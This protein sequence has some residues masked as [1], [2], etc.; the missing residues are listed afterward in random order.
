MKKCI[1]FSFLLLA[2]TAKIN[3]SQ[4]AEES[5]SKGEGLAEGSAQTEVTTGSHEI[6]TF[7]GGCFWCMGSPFEKLEGV[8]E[9]I[10]G[11]TGGHKDN[12]T[13]KEVSSGTTG[14]LEAIQIKYDPSQISYPDL[15]EVFWRQVDPTDPGGQFVDRGQQYTTAIF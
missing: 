12:P 7:A 10:S 1:I 5:V 4:P 9:V 13:Y 6:A 15:L 3:C 14:H 8:K 2:L 11:Y